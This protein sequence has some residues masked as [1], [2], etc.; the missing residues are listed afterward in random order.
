MNQLLSRRNGI[1]LI[2]IMSMVG[3]FEAQR[4]MFL[5]HGVDRLT[6]VIV[7]LAADLLTAI[8]ASIISDR[9]VVSGKGWAF[10]VMVIAGSGSVTANWLAGT[11]AVDKAAHIALVVF[12]LCGEF[13]NSRVRV[14]I[15]PVTE[16]VVEQ[17]AEPQP[18]TAAIASTKRDAYGPRN[19]AKGYSKRHQQRLA[20]AKA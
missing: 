19:P 16:T 2:M 8:M 3:S 15:E 11:N 4:G 5:Q 17:Q 6:A 18:E 7:P 12:Y 20:A 9:R 14:R 13:V 1:L 10:S